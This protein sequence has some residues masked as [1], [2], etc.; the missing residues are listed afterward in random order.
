[1]KNSLLRFTKAFVITAALLGLSLQLQAQSTNKP[2]AEKSSSTAAEADKTRKAG[3]FH[4]KI[5]AIDRVAKTITIG[6]RTFQITSETK[7]KKAGKPATLEAGTVGEVA[8]G[9]VKPSP[10]G[11]LVATTLNFGPKVSG[12]ATEK[13]K[14]SSE[15]EKEAK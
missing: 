14:S 3:P 8:S 6:K 4:G 11:K 9:Y 13:P 12:D 5:V 10:E 7:I 1:M 2:A 15:K